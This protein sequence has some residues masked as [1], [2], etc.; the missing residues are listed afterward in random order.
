M[1]MQQRPWMNK[2]GNNL[3]ISEL[4]ES[5]KNWKP[6]IW[7][8]FLKETVDVSLKETLLES[9]SIENFPFQPNQED[10]NSIVDRHPHLELFI[11]S[12]MKSLTIREYQVIYSIFWE[13]KTQCEIAK[14]LKIT[15]S[16]TRNYRDRSLKKLGALFIEKLMPLTTPKREKKSHN[17]PEKHIPTQQSQIHA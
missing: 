13:G 2:S 8:E 1:T 15:R 9:M 6:T 14:S 5:A 7:E 11:R 4:Q 3:S 17:L 16:A 10:T 12:S